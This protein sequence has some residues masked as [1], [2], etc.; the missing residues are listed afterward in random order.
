MQNLIEYTNRIL[1]DCICYCIFL[2]IESDEF[3]TILKPVKIAHTL[4]NILSSM[5]RTDFLFLLVSQRFPIPISP[6]KCSPMM[7][8]F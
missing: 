6:S 3:K 8:V 4:N 7:R 1:N 2:D 5:C